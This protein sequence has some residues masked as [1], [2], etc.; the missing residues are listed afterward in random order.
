MPSVPAFIKHLRGGAASSPIPFEPVSQRIIKKK[1]DRR[2]SGAHMGLND[3]SLLY[4]A[5]SESLDS[6]CEG[7]TDLEGQDGMH[8]RREGLEESMDDKATR[9]FGVEIAARNSTPDVVAAQTVH[10]ERVTP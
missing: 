10:S 2:P 4:S 3:R 8:T 7:V 5:N 6:R 9:T 1:S